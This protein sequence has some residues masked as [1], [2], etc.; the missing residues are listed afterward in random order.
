MK[1]FF[2][3]IS[4]GLACLF[5]GIGAAAF[6]WPEVP[7]S[8][9]AEAPQVYSVGLC[10]LASDPAKYDGKVVRVA[11]QYGWVNPTIIGFLQTRGCGKIIRATCPPDQ[12]GCRVLLSLQGDNPI[13]RGE[14][15]VVGRFIADDRTPL[16]NEHRLEI[17]NV[18]RA[19]PANRGGCTEQVAGGSY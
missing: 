3:G 7:E 16:R 15:E 18:L 12:T 4:I 9:V 13:Y 6:A 11:A 10:D 17:W 1:R 8:T 19:A 2:T 5:V 14:V